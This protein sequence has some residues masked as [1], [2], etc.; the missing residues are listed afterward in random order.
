M[1]AL[2]PEAFQLID[3]WHAAQHLGAA[4][5]HILPQDSTARST[6]FKRYRRILRDDPDG[7]EKVIRSLRYYGTA[8]GRLDA[9]LESELNY[10]RNHRNRMSYAKHQAMNIPIGS[11]VTES[12]CKTLVGAKMKRSGQRWGMEGGKAILAF[13][14]LV[15]S[16][17]FDAA[18]TAILDHHKQTGAHS[19]WSNADPVVARG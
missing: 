2:V 3:F 16:E 7:A 10:F 17:R 1:A 8:S 15:K 12:A 9:G 6:W 5:E 13:R 19:V 14:A 18:R 11:G 4:A